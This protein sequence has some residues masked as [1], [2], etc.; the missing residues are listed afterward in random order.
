M[1]TDYKTKPGYMM[2][3]MNAYST[4]ML[5]ATLVVSG[6]LG[7]FVNFLTRFPFVINWILQFAAMSAL[8]QL[9]IFLSITTF[10]PLVC[11]LITTT[12]KFFTVLS[13]VILFGNSLSLQQW[14]GT[15]LVFLG[16]G[17]DMFFGKQQAH[18]QQLS[19][20]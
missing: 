16:L 18:H 5:A 17:L 10:S 20:R 2:L 11:S 6:E 7:E 12:R 8:G 9:F 3:W 19:H 4:L 13:S 1:K 15:F 14:L